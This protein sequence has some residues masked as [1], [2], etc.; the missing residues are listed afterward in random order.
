MLTNYVSIFCQQNLSAN[1]VNKFCLQILLANS[2][3]KILLPKLCQQ[4]LSCTVMRASKGRYTRL[5]E[6]KGQ[7]HTYRFF[8]T[9]AGHV[10]GSASKSNEEAQQETISISGWLG[11]HAHKHFYEGTRGAHMTMHEA[12]DQWAMHSTSFGLVVDQL[13]A[14]SVKPCQQMKVTSNA[15]DA[16]L[17]GP[18]PRA[19]RNIRSICTRSTIGLGLLRG[20]FSVG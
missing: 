16:V 5:R 10:Y 15:R 12:W 18:P 19:M 11:L 6:T 4:I 3:T 14:F 2:V 13:L 1:Y 8:P 17:L 20:G 7:N 9:G